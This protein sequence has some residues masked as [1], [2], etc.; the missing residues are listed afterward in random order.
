MSLSGLRAAYFQGSLSSCVGALG[1]CFKICGTAPLLVGGDEVYVSVREQ[2]C[3]CVCA[4]VYLC[5]CA[6]VCVCVSVCICCMYV[7]KHMHVRAHVYGCACVHMCVACMRVVHS[8]C[9]L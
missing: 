4:R 7:C 6:F 3:V 8:T 2:V 9:V 5:T 1:L